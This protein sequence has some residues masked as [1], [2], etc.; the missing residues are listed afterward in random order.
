MPA[1]PA[2]RRPRGKNA[3]EW[4]DASIPAGEGE[5]LPLRIYGERRSGSP[6]PLVIHFHGGEFV[7][8]CLDSGIAVARLLAAAGAVVVSVG[9]PL[10]PARPFPAAVEAGYAALLWAQRTRGQLAGRGARLYVAGEEAGGNLAAAVALV[11]RDRQ[12]PLLAGQILL[13]PMLDACMGT[14]SLRER[15]AGPVGC[16]WADGWC[17]YL[18]SPAAAEHPYA[19]P[20][21]A[22]RL[23]GLPPT[24]LL[25]AQDDPLRDEAHDYGRRLHEAGLPVRE[26]VLPA[27]TGWPT[28]LFDAA[29]AEAPWSETVT[30]RLNEF[31]ADTL[32]PPAP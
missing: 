8:G 12:A 2:L 20:G 27:P 14:A 31:F 24:L 22:L 5:P 21:R 30:R 15:N 16:K 19:M 11:A 18:G 25:T 10:A 23:A 9:Y 4:I 28:A 29:R 32:P 1:D 26:S 6:Q 17:K 7:C 3:P 13:S